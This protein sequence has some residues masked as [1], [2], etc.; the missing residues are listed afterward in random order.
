M[1]PVQGSWF[2]LLLTV[3]IQKTFNLPIKLL[4]S[5]EVLLMDAVAKEYFQMMGQNT[6]ENDMHD[7]VRTANTNIKSWSLV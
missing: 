1:F 6:L 5:E 7:V 2:V 4:Q 3:P